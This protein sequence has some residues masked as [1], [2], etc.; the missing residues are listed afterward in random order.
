M[1]R[2]LDT[3][4]DRTLSF[5]TDA[6]L[7]RR[8][9]IVTE[10]IPANLRWGRVLAQLDQLAE[11][12]ALR[13]VRRTT[14]EARVVTAAVDDIVLHI[15]ADVTR[16]L[17]L[18]ARINYVGRSSMEVGIRIDQDPGAPSLASCYFT[19][20]ARRGELDGASSIPVEPLEYVDDMER[21]RRAMAVERRRSYQ[22]HRA[23]SQEAPGASDYLLLAELH[24]AQDD[25]AFD[26]LLVGDLARSSWERMYPDQENV[27]EKIFGGSL[28]Q[29]AFELAHLHAEELAPDR[30]IVA[31][32]DRINF[33]QPVRIGD[34]LHFTS[35]V[36]YTG[37]TSLCVEITIER[38]SL[39]RVTRALSNTCVF[40]FVNVD[41]DLRPLPVPKVFPTTYAE[42]ARYLEA[43][44]RRM[45]HKNADGGILVGV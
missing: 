36:V 28:I 16:D 6:A 11:D 1:T 35:R 23:K 7:R 40:T 25:P 27:P 18:H 43:H 21:F 39:D 20:V 32:V 24:A 34:K 45:R 14:P 42:D 33:L 22:R 31:R 9:M 38:Q 15:P 13:Y 12:V 30:P 44:R 29:R 26:Q 19:M 3:S 41:Q 10:N 17:H 2:P 4:I 5:S 8:F 37:E